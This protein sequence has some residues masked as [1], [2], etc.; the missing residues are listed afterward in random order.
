MSETLGLTR[1]DW[2]DVLRASARSLPAEGSPLGAR[3]RHFDDPLL[4]WKNE[5]V[6]EVEGRSQEGG[7]LCGY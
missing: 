7:E 1:V 4:A 2:T 5:H 6:G 3:T